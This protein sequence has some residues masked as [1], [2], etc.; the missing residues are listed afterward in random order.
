MEKV[1]PSECERG[2]AHC[3]KQKVLGG[4]RK[5]DIWDEVDSSSDLNDGEGGGHGSDFFFA[6]YLR[7]IGFKENNTVLLYNGSPK[8]NQ[9]A[10][11]KVLN[12][13]VG[14]KDLQQ[15]ADAVIRLRAEYLFKQKRFSALV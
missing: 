14:K 5:I 3:N 13:G 9:D 4:K 15:C 10:H 11:Y 6:I 1:S 12:I 2:S 7:E 8:G